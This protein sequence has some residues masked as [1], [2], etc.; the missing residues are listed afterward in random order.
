M[1]KLVFVCIS[2]LILFT[3]CEAS[4]PNVKT[5]GGHKF[6]QVQFQG[7]PELAYINKL[8]YDA[9]VSILNMSLRYF[10]EGK[11]SDSEYMNKLM[12]YSRI[13]ADPD[14]LNS[15]EALVKEIGEYSAKYGFYVMQE[16]YSVAADVTG[17]V[18]NEPYTDDQMWKI[19]R[20]DD[21]R[22]RM[23]Y[24]I[25]T[26]P[27]AKFN[28]S[29]GIKKQMDVLFEYYNN[30]KDITFADRGTYLK[31]SALNHEYNKTMRMLIFMTEEQAET[32]IGLEGEVKRIQSLHD[33]IR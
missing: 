1:K 16:L 11:V 23:I 14:L 20:D 19:L 30:V 31:A 22:K 10:N 7:E 5:F 21:L 26:F 29:R 27:H 28:M 15:Y 4:D 6:I 33:N 13:V 17:F 9:I 25:E 18:S 8:Q 32:V 3:A 12:S 24:V 2:L